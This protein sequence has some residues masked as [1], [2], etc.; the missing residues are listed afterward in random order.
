MP[1]VV[2]YTFNP[3]AW[4]AQRQAVSVSSRPALVY[5]ASSRPATDIQLDPDSKQSKQTFC[6]VSVNIVNTSNILLL[7][8]MLYVFLPIFFKLKQV[9]FYSNPFVRSFKEEINKVCIPRIN[10]TW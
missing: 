7:S 5:I 9:G 3:N 1:G 2:V 4:E 6:V 10:F 8:L